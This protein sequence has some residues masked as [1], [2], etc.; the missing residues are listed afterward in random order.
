MDD[1]ARELLRAFFRKWS[2][3]DLTEVSRPVM[4]SDAR[5][6]RKLLEEYD[7]DTS[8][9]EA[10]EQARDRQWFA[11]KYQRLIK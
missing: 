10:A 7:E 5:V 2:T 8:L 3:H 6:L 9:L 11:A 1:E 4:A